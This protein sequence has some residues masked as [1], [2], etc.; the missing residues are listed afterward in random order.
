MSKFKNVM[1][2]GLVSILSFSLASCT[3]KLEKPSED[4][5]PDVGEPSIPDKPTNPDKPTEPDEPVIPPVTP[6]EPG[7]NLSDYYLYLSDIGYIKDN[8]LSYTKYDVIRVDSGIDGR[9][10]T[11][12][13]DDENVVYY[14]GFGAHAESQLAFD[15]TDYK[16][17]Y[18]VLYAKLGVDASRNGNGDVSFIISGSNNKTDWTKIE[19]ISHI[20][21][22]DNAYTL[23]VNVSEYNYIKIFSGT[24]G[25]NHADHSIIADAR[26]VKEDYDYSLDNYDKLSTLE[27]YD[28][29]LRK[30]DHKENVKNHRD[31]IYK[32]EFVNRLGNINNISNLIRSSQEMKNTFDFILKDDNL[33]LLIESGE[34]LYFNNVIK[35]LSKLYNTFKDDLNSNEGYT[36][37]KIMIALAVAYSSD[38]Y[39]STLQF[40]IPLP[41]YDVLVRYELIKKLY[42]DNKFLNKEQFKN[43]NMELL[44]MVVN[45]ALPNDEVLW[46]R[47]YSEK[48]YPKLNER[49][50]IYKH[51]PYRHPLPNMMIDDYFDIANKDK[52]NNKYYLSEYGV[53]YGLNDDGSKTPRMWMRM[54]AGGICWNVARLGQD[55]NKVH[56]VPA[57][58]TYQPGHEAYFTYQENDKGEGYWNLMNDVSSWGGS[59]TH[60]GSGGNYYRMLLGWSH[61]PLALGMN[62]DLTINYSSK[63]NSS[64]IALA[65]DALNH[66]DKF[67]ESMSYIYLSNSY[68]DIKTKEE[69]YNEAVK[70]LDINFLAY[71]KLLEV[72]KKNNVDSK[73]WLE[74]GKMAAK[75]FKY[76]PEAI[77]D[78]LNFI[79]PN[80]TNTDKFDLIG[81]KNEVLIN[82]KNVTSNDTVHHVQCKKLGEHFLGKE[83]VPLASFSFDGVNANTIVINDYY[84]DYNFQLG[85]SF[86]GGKTWKETSDRKILLTEE[87]IKLIGTEFG[88]WVKI[89]GSSSIH[90]IEIKPGR[91]VEN[92]KV[93]INDLENRLTGDT[94]H[95]EYSFDQINWKLYDNKVRFN[96]NVT[97]YVRYRPYS[98]YLYGNPKA[99]KFN[100][101][102]TD[103]NFKY[104]NLENI[105]LVSVGTPS[106]NGNDAKNMLD[107]SNFTEWRTQTNIYAKDKA[108][109]VKFDKVR[110]ISK[111]TYDPTT[112]NGRIRDVEIYISTDN[113]RWELV[114]KATNW[115][116]NFDRKQVIINNPKE[117]L[118]MK[119]L[120][121]HTYAIK[122]E[123]ENKFVSGKR[124]DFFEKI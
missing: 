104:I 13:V 27:E 41:S 107:G 37:K 72:Y 81:I 102:S 51:M 106:Q 30:Y 95:L 50:D 118:Y 77:V 114:G 44:R 8:T 75:S 64:Y 110:K 36:Y 33:T 70:T 12:K 120:P 49:L 58:G 94:N 96:G 2:L 103:N 123:E 109:I 89:M 84:K 121:T 56:G 68:T 57:I 124:F 113:S 60:T 67:T 62:Q 116:N 9:D 97:V 42:D 23:K 87:D 48:R 111:I 99:F 14:K 29:Y 78:I 19:E 31:I 100:T 26:L 73:K 105:S 108:F 25:V 40:G 92:N 38:R 4:T 122:Q 83:V 101:D 59:Y 45:I 20:T 18:P 66:Y 82:A 11:L 76:H 17:K 35:T 7:V 46:L 15:I 21:S 98:Q 47:G 16:G 115:G 74:L 24:N 5:T 28:N 43:Y 65:Q 63:Y 90:K 39:A 112:Q 86:D 53:K 88:V 6:E 34:S 3:A 79:L 10:M 117:A 55:L 32:R 22:K 85:Y 61:L 80:L 119:I 69:L 54:E 91:D 1:L 71:T 93:S 52:Y